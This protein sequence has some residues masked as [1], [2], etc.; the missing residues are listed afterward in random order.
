M[1][2]EEAMH[3]DSLLLSLLENL[4][5]NSTNGILMEYTPLREGALSR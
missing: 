4:R 1:T 5:V 3:L 2:E